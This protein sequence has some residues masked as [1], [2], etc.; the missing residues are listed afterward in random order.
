M[1]LAYKH[2]DAK[3]RIAELSVGQW[4]GIVIGLGV[5]IVWGVY[6]SPFGA[7]PTLVSAIY[8]GALPAGSALVGNVT[9]V[10]PWLI[11]RSAVDWRRRDGRFL[12][13]AGAEAHGYVVV[14]DPSARRSARAVDAEDGGDLASL[15]ETA[16]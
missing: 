14:P 1:N 13:G 15:W 3:L 11:V 6:L 4:I 2:L 5:G 8:L 9:S 7:T 12:P 16:R 10:S